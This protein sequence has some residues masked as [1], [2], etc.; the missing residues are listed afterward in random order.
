MA[1]EKVGA[2][3]GMEDGILGETD[4]ACEVGYLETIPGFGVG[5][6]TADTIDMGKLVKIIVGTVDG[7]TVGLRVEL[8]TA[9]TLDVGTDERIVVGTV[10]GDTVG[11]G[12]ELGTA[13]TLEVGKDV[14][15][16]VGTADDKT[17]GRRDLLFGAVVGYLE[18]FTALGVELGTTDKLAVGKIVRIVGRGCLVGAREIVG[19]CEEF[20]GLG[21]IELIFVGKLD[22]LGEDVRFEDGDTEIGCELGM[23]DILLR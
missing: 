11:P 1:E 8:G 14:R 6:G 12:V 15:I 19:K 16:I 17:V 10:D 18:A 3:V 7:D 20:A 4:G 23:V 13:D 22:G 2:L 21:A 5:L 9:D